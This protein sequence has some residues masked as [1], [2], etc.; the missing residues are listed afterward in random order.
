MAR[1]A[2]GVDV[3]R[4]VLRA[5]RLRRARPHPR[6]EKLLEIPLPGG[7]IQD[8]LVNDPDALAKAVGQALPKGEP[9]AL[10]ICSSQMDA[11][12]LSLP[13]MGRN[14][15][16]E[17]IKWE[18]QT[19]LRPPW[20]H[21]EEFLFDFHPLSG[22]EEGGSYLVVCLPRA[23][24]YSYLTPLHRMGIYPGIVDVVP[25]P[26]LFADAHRRE[27]TGYLVIGP[28]LTHILL[29]LDGSWGLVRTIPWGTWHLKGD[30]QSEEALEELGGYLRQTLEYFRSQQ[31]A[32]SYTELLR[33]LVVGGIG[34]TNPLLLEF[35]TRQTGLAVGP[36][37]PF[38]DLVVGGRIDG[39]LLQ[40]G[41]AFAL[42]V[43]LARRGL[44][45]L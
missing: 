30:A 17:A 25:F 39:T 42:A 12:R 19:S 41:P 5:V 13:P 23:I 4:E 36:S 2:W 26:I 38:I 24:L 21:G 18:I 34:G 14:E 15:L 28:E 40:A 33:E 45:E 27:E 20:E 1:S 35:L 29:N 3:N 37:D 10:S 16:R 6:L 22:G 32:E 9:V 31:R 11:R 8:G 7:A 44:A 43:G